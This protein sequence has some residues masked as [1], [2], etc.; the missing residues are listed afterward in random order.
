MLRA[1][2]FLLTALVFSTPSLAQNL[3]VSFTAGYAEYGVEG[4]DC[5]P[6]PDADGRGGDI[7]LCASARQFGTSLVT[8]ALYKRGEGGGGFVAVRIRESF[9]PNIAAELAVHTHWRTNRDNGPL[10]I[11]ALQENN[12]RD[13]SWASGVELGA[14]YIFMEGSVRPSV[15][16]GGGILTFSDDGSLRFGNSIRPSAFAGA[17]VELQ[18]SKRTFF[19]VDG[20]LRQAFTRGRT[21]ARGAEL[22]GGIGFRF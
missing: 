19:R 1:C 6:T 21:L 17:S 10:P 20:R 12:F 18:A 22:S 13:G 7:P 5:D 4:Y 11:Q 14:E 3:S 15:T 9:S 16:L 2:L 8:P